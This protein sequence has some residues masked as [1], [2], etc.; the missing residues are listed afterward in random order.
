MTPIHVRAGRLFAGKYDASV[1]K[2]KTQKKKKSFLE[3]KQKPVKKREGERESVCVCRA[4]FVSILLFARKNF[5]HFLSFF[6][7]VKS[8]RERECVCQCVCVFVCKKTM[9]F[10]P[11][12]SDV[13]IHFHKKKIKIITGK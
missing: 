2:N 13:R 4:L 10:A 8:L 11:S 6:G 12:P 9:L 7:I 3:Q 5:E 1:G